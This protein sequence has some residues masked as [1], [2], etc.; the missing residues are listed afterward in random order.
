MTTSSSSSPPPPPPAA[1]ATQALLSG[2][3]AG[4]SVDVALFPLDT[5]KTRLQSKQGFRAAGGFRGV[6]NGLSSAVIGSAPGAA[7]FFVGYEKTKAALVRQFGTSKDGL[8]SP[9]IHMAAA[10]LG[11]IAACIA[12]V[13]TEVVK[14]RMQAGQHSSIADA[15]RNIAKSDAGLVRG[16]YRGYLTTVAR[17]IPFTCIQFSLY[18]ALRASYAKRLGRERLDD[19]LRSAMCGFVSGGVAAGLTTPLDVVKTRVMLSRSGSMWDTA[20]EIVRE[21]G[22]RALT[23]G[24]VPRVIWI[25][26]GGFI[27]LGAYEQSKIILS[28]KV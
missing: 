14:Q 21:E 4:L 28:D 16:L 23:K 3:M 11:E 8:P 18:E 1:T 19:G 27:F 7:L 12:R 17:E 5:L 22:P 9:F 26:I 25:S 20:K 15:I 13:P 24:F 2:A 10:S 6:Y